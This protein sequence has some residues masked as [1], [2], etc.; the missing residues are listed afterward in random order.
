[1]PD[2]LLEIWGDAEVEVVVLGGPQLTVGRSQHNDVVLA[3]DTSTSRLHATIEQYAGCWCVRDLGSMNGTS[4]N[5]Q[6]VNDQQ[7]LFD[8]D[9]I[10]VGDTRMYLRLASAAAP[11]NTD[12]PR[13]A[14][15]LTPRERDVLL[16]LLRPLA[17][18]NVVA[19]LAVPSEIARMLDVSVAAVRQ[20]L[21]NLYTKFGVGAGGR[22][23]VRLANEV[24]SRGAV[25]LTELRQRAPRAPRLSSRCRDAR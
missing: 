2:D 13:P 4:V 9:E 20:H 1:M 11:D 6:L 3:G 12:V 21:T 17:S 10:R 22:R 16:C 7:R 5:G 25:H 14:P 24:L 23:N 15:A 18:A 8:G 19:E